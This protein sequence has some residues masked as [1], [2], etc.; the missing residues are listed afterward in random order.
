VRAAILLVIA[1]NR[2][3][4]SPTPPPDDQ[5]GGIDRLDPAGVVDHLVPDSSSGLTG[6]MDV[7]NE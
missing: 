6:R 7:A 3:P 1:A 2:Y 4:S 5:R